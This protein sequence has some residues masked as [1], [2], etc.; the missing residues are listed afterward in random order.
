MFR[1]LLSFW[2]EGGLI[3]ALLLSIG[4]FGSRQALAFLPGALLVLFVAGGMGLT[5]M[6][7]QSHSEPKDE[8]S[9]RGGW[10]DRALWYGALFLSG[11][12]SV[13]FLGSLL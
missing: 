5:I 3:L 10:G 12:A 1:E 4:Y 9:E 7:A 11:T 2:N 8:Y 13:T 6:M